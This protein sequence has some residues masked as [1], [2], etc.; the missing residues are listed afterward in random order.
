MKFLVWTLF[1]IFISLAARAE[2]TDADN[3]LA[4]QW[5]SEKTGDNIQINADLSIEHSK[6][7]A[8]DLRRVSGKRYEMSVY[9]SGK[10]GV[11]Q[12]RTCSLVFTN[13]SDGSMNALNLGKDPNC[14]LG[15]M[16][17]ITLNKAQPAV[18][19]VGGAR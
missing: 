13:R 15:V 2:C 18:N 17:R 3:K 19:A 7:G 10:K 8:G 11:V 4:G 9:H 6:L 5:H 16:E 14:D 12:M 1:S